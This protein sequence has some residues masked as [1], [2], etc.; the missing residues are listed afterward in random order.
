VRT[1]SFIVIASAALA[2]F[3][4]ARADQMKGFAPIPVKDWS[5]QRAKSALGL[6]SSLTND[7]P[8]SLEGSQSLFVKI[9][10]A[11]DKEISVEVTR[12]GLLDDSVASDAHRIIARQISGEWRVVAVGVKRQCA[13]GRASWTIAK[14]V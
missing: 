11:S 3:S 1:T 14:C 9:G 5:P 8:E 12:S 13:I 10:K 4:P 7:F 2:F 6:V